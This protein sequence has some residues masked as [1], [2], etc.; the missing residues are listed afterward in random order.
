MTWTPRHNGSL[1]IAGDRPETT[2]L[3]AFGFLTCI[4]DSPVIR[5][6]GHPGQSDSSSLD[7]ARHRSAAPGLK[8]LRAFHAYRSSRIV[9]IHWRESKEVARRSGSDNVRHVTGGQRN[10]PARTYEIINLVRVQEAK[11]GSLQMIERSMSRRTEAVRTA[12]S[13]AE[14]TPRS[15]VPEAVLE[16]SAAPASPAERTIMAMTQA[17]A[18]GARITEPRPAAAAAARPAAEPA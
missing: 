5:G 3:T 15:A 13:A 7:E 11:H 8:A 1:H 4:D 2:L 16:K 17:S 6:R 10:R 12:L 14:S 9:G 18:T